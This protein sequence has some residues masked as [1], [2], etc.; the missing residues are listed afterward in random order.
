[1]YI[2]PLIDSH[3]IHLISY[4]L[5]SQH[6]CNKIY[7][8]LATRFGT[9][10]AVIQA[11]FSLQELVPQYGK[12]ICLEGGDQIVAS[13]LVQSNEDSQDASYIKMPELIPHVFFGQLKHLLVLEVPSI[14][15]LLQDLPTKIIFA[16]VQSI[17]SFQENNVNYYTNLGPIK[18]VDLSAIE[19]VVG[20]VKDG[21]HWG[22]VDRSN[23]AENVF[24]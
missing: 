14:P 8:A 24:D 6:I 12:V 5:I 11:A 3:S 18:I 23:V 4:A 16:V 1:M 2:M 13:E 17:R 10:R 22:V 20:R 7:A 9:S 19:C 15:Q 21:N